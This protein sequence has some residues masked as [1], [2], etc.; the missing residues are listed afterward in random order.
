MLS[1]RLELKL[2]KAVS[3]VRAGDL[4]YLT[5]EIPSQWKN[6]GSGVA[7]LLWIKIK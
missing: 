7:R 3:R 2:K 1:G 5:T 4:V 6:P